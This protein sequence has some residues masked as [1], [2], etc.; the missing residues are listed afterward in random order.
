MTQHGQYEPY[1]QG[2]Q[3]PPYSS[4]RQYEDA[5][6]RSRGWWQVPTAAVL[7]AALATAG[8]WTLA[9]NG[10]IGSGESASPSASQVAQG[11]PEGSPDHR[12]VRDHHDDGLGAHARP[13][14]TYSGERCPA[15]SFRSL[16]C[17]SS[18]WARARSRS[19]SVWTG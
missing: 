11:E 7:S 4:S 13:P 16:P 9:E 10:V 5:P 12:E 8:T 15:G 14:S 19:W 17:S 6:R 18:S 2:D 3:Y 1:G